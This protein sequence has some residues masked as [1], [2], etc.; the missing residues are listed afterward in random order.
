[1][2]TKASQRPKK[3]VTFCSGVET[4]IDISTSFLEALRNA[5]KAIMRV[6]GSAFSVDYKADRSP[7]TSADRISNEIITAFLKQQYS[8]PVLSEEGKDMP[9]EERRNW[10]A[11]WLV[12]PLDGTKEFISRN[13]EFTVNVALIEEGEP[14]MGAIYLPAKDLLYYAA[15][16]KGSYKIV[17]HEK[18]PLPLPAKRQGL[19][20]VGSRSHGTREFDEFLKKLRARYNDVAFVSAGSSLKFCLVAEGAADI[21]PRLGPTMEWDTAA[22]HVIVEEAGGSVVQAGSNKPLRYNKPDLK[23][24]HFIAKGRHYHDHG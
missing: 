20:V 4:E 15:R 17:S 12:D 8:F 19:T 11:F 23:N 16:G 6:Y 13:G 10:K 3:I 2:Q 1:M 22:G 14:V 9:F 24:G 21:Y 5:G 18:V 7:L